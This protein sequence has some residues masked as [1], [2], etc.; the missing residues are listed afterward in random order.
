[1]NKTQLPESTQKNLNS[2]SLRSMTS[3]LSNFSEEEKERI[4]NLS[5]EIE[6]CHN[7]DISSIGSKSEEINSMTRQFLEQYK[8][9]DVQEMGNVLTNI[10]KICKAPRNQKGLFGKMLC[11]F[12]DKVDDIKGFYVS[13]QG[14]LDK[15]T[16]EFNRQKEEV[17]K[18]RLAMEHLIDSLVNVYLENIETFEALKISRDVLQKKIENNAS[19]NKFKELFDNEGDNFRLNQIQQRIGELRADIL[20]TE[21]ELLLFKI[22]IS[23]SGKAESHLISLCDTNIK[24]WQR[25]GVLNVASLKTRNSLDLIDAFK[26]GTNEMIK[27]SVDIVLENSKKVIKSTNDPLIKLETIE[28]AQKSILN[29]LEAMKE[30]YQAIEKNRQAEDIHL[31][32]LYDK[33]KVKKLSNNNRVNI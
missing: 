30:E 5:K 20:E 31:N 8:L 26:A 11:M 4:L 28:Y 2:L 6:N 23:T 27:N 12:G 7:H 3:D 13:I 9:N 15:L 21:Q 1:M 16:Q 24:V 25:H 10:T 17:V 32:A 19:S 14:H 22:C 29:S 18:S 33:M